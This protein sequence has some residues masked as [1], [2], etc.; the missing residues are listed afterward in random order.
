MTYASAWRKAGSLRLSVRHE[1][2]G[3]DLDVVTTR[4]RT[5]CFPRA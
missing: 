4:D 1:H 2:Y 5:R 3:V